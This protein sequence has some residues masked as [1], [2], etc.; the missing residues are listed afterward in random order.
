MGLLA[1]FPLSAALAVLTKKKFEEMSFFSVCVIIINIILSG[2]FGST[3]YGVYVNCLLIA[4]SVVICI[5]SIRRDIQGFKSAVF[6]SGSFA[7]VLFYIIAAAMYSGFAL[8]GSDVDRVYGP[9]IANMWMNDDLGG[10]MPEWAGSLLYVA[11][12]VPSWSYF[13]LKLWPDYSDGICMMSYFIYCVTALLPIFKYVKR[14][15]WIKF[16]LLFGAVFSLFNLNYEESISVYYIDTATAVTAIFGL[17]MIL[18]V[19]KGEKI[20][21]V[22]IIEAACSLIIISVIKRVGG[23]AG[24]AMTS[25]LSY[26][27]FERIFG[28]RRAGKKIRENILP[29]LCFLSASITSCGFGLYKWINGQD[30]LKASYTGVLFFAAWYVTGVICWLLKE[31]IDRKK[32]I[33]F[34]VL[35][36]AIPTSCFALTRWYFDRKYGNGYS[37]KVLRIFG[38]VLFNASEIDGKVVRHWNQ[39][40]FPLIVLV[41]FAI[42][43]IIY[44]CYEV[45]NINDEF[46]NM[47][48]ISVAVIGGYMAWLF[49]WFAMYLYHNREELNYVYCSVRYMCAGSMTIYSFL[50]YVLVRKD[51]LRNNKLLF[52]TVAALFMSTYKYQEDIFIAKFCQGRKEYTEVYEMAGLNLTSN[53]KIFY[54]DTENRYGSEYF[55]YFSFPALAGSIPGGRYTR[56]SRQMEQ[57]SLEELTEVVSVYDYVFI[58]SI[59]D[60]FKQNYYQMFAGGIDSIKDNS[61]YRVNKDNCVKLELLATGD[62]EYISNLWRLE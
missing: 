45:K 21:L 62:K 51:K 22:Y 16:L 47:K 27:T 43:L 37:I 46:E 3:L 6:T 4:A 19:Y 1:V 48:N 29:T 9:Q 33:W 34:A 31:L 58:D 38:G 17:F 32:Y 41:I 44:M 28:Y 57:I 2:I 53:D 18:E 36:S 52:F 25:C 11:P 61:L 8:I 59:T 23:A 20:D 42:G 5:R 40:P 14:N 7:L 30:S 39:T 60:E 12:V 13:C 54:I 49:M 10:K 50:L 26:L 24:F 35:F 56:F 15:E 55:P